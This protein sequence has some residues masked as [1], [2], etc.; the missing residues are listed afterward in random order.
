MCVFGKPKAP[1][2]V[3]PQQTVQPQDVTAEPQFPTDPKERYQDLQTRKQQQK[4]AQATILTGGNPGPL[5]ALGKGT[6]L[7]G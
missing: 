1:T 5:P 3:M 7:T 2:I 6:V 4:L